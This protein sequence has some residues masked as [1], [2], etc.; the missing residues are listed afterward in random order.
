MSIAR[1]IG[2]DRAV[3][4]ELEGIDRRLGGGCRGRHD[5]RRGPC[6]RVYLV[7]FLESP[8][9]RGRELEAS[10]RACLWW[11]AMRQQRCN[12]RR[13]P[14][15]SWGASDMGAW[16]LGSSHHTTRVTFVLCSNITLL[17]ILQDFYFVPVVE[18]G[19]HRVSA[20]M[21][22]KLRPSLR[23]LRELQRA[24]ELQHA[25]ETPNIHRPAMA[26]P[27][28]GEI[29]SN[30]SLE[31]LTFAKNLSPLRCFVICEHS[32]VLPSSAS[33]AATPGAGPNCPVRIP[34]D[35]SEGDETSLHPLFQILLFVAR[36]LRSH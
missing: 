29:P 1:S 23:A 11:L 12:M 35:P 9:D 4:V 2:T 3:R 8:S 24:T 20:V 33:G 17:A 28:G 26:I 13:R 16:R 21:F 15:H 7:I 30:Q 19:A 27:T 34:V 14:R 31:H 36:M 22:V 18:N 10:L 32:G 5:E 6:T 25:V